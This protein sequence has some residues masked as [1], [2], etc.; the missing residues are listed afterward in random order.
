MSQP[1]IEDLEGD[2]AISRLAATALTQQLQSAH[3]Q[4]ESD[5]RRIHYLEAKIAALEQLEQKGRATD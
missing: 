1:T 3:A 2:L 4:I 5:R